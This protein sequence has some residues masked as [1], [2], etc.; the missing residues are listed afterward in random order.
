MESARVEGESVAKNIGWQLK[1]GDSN[2]KRSAAEQVIIAIRQY[3]AHE[4]PS[5]TYG[6]LLS[7]ISAQINRDLGDLIDARQDVDSILAV[8]QSKRKKR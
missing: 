6:R 4:D 3:G 2:L 8:V 5:G 7:I 1:H